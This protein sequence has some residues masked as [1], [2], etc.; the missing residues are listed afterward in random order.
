MYTPYTSLSRAK[1]PRREWI[2]STR[3]H[4]SHPLHQPCQQTDPSSP[5]SWPPSEP[6]RPS[7]KAPRPPPCQILPQPHTPP[8]TSP[9]PPPLGPRIPAPYPPKPPPPNPP[10]P[11]TKA[12]PQPPFKRPATCNIPANTPLP[13]SPAR[14]ALAP[15]PSAPHPP[16]AVVVA[17]VPLVADNRHSDDGA[18]TVPPEAPASVTCSAKRNGISAGGRRR[19]RRSSTGWA[20]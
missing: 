8:R 7:T 6:T 16:A 11:P 15:V 12:S 1:V 4:I 3:K 10:P 14:P 17:L 5:T 13:L 18:R 20:S 19:G 2:S 9:R